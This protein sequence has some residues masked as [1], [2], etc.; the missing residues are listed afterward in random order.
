MLLRAG[1]SIPIVEGLSASDEL[2][3]EEFLGFG[4]AWDVQGFLHQVQ[5]FCLRGAFVCVLGALAF[6]CFVSGLLALPLCG[7]ALTSLCRLCIDR[8][9]G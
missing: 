6:P 8:G 4:L 3:T 1:W 9:H 2:I 5:V 7:A